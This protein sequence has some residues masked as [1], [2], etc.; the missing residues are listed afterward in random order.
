MPSCAWP[1]LTARPAWSGEGGARRSCVGGF[2][3][4]PPSRLLDRALELTSIVAANSPA[5][6]RRSRA[7]RLDW[8]EPLLLDVLNRGWDS[9]RED[10]SHPDAKEGS[11]AFLERREP[12]RDDQT[13]F[14][15]RPG[16]REGSD[17]EPRM[18]AN[19]VGGLLKGFNVGPTH[20]CWRFGRVAGV[21]ACFRATSVRHQEILRWSISG[22]FRHHVFAND[23]PLV[24]HSRGLAWVIC[25][26]SQSFP[27]SRE[28]Y[29]MPRQ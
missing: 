10:W 11:T 20:K 29:G 14:R 2:P 12:E 13:F 19:D 23:L 3:G 25:R 27:Y 28:H 9:I 24:A 8:E 18:L 5:A 21:A 1:C 16:A 7:A 15:R 6:V 26:R 4:Q 22:P 17:S